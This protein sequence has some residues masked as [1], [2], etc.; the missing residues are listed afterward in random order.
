MVDR[1]S[2][3]TASTSQDA[4]VVV[5]AVDLRRLVN[6]YYQN[7]YR[8]AFRLCGNESDAEDLTQQ[9]FFVV[10]TRLHQLRE[11][12]KVERWMFAVLRSCFLKS[13]RRQRPVAAANLELEV[14]E[15]PEHRIAES[16]LD[17]QD[18]Q[19][20]LNEL[21]DEFRL[22]V[23]MFYFEDLS[24]QEIADRLMLPI[25][26]V[27]SRLSRAKA[28]LRHRLFVEDPVATSGRAAK[29]SL[30]SNK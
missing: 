23:L 29:S 25:G 4:S 21:P 5:A 10:Q 18:L 6:E 20:A 24:Y 15:V 11:P 27:M 19:Q 9:T 16:S 8:Y 2:L 3:P 13:R 30:G 26:T 28:R 12:D 17:K 7:V 22:V 1:S 14:D